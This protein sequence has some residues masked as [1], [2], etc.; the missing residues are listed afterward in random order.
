MKRHAC[1]LLVACA[2][3]C[4]RGPPE[5]AK[6]TTIASCRYDVRLASSG[7]AV[8]DA[9]CQSDGSMSF[10]PAQ[11]YLL[12]YLSANTTNRSGHLR[13]PQAKLRYEV[14]L[15]RLA[16]RGH[17]ADRAARV[18]ESFIAAMSSI[19]LVP[20]PL[21]T[22]IPVTVQLSAEPGVALATGLKRGDA[23][24]AYQ[25]MAH[26]IPVATYLAFGKLEQLEL[27]V[28]GSTLELVR[29][30]GSLDQPSEQLS[31]WIA[32]SAVAVSDFYGAFPMPR[33]SVMVIP[34]PGRES[35]VFGK[36]LPESEPA[37]ALVVGQRATKQKLYQDWILVHE[38]FHLGFPSF[39][40]EG[41]WLDEGLATYYEP[42]IR[43]R[44]GL[45]SER[46]LWRELAQSLP[47]GLEAYTELGLEMASDFRGI[48]W[49]GALACLEADV[50]A[51]RRKLDRGLE[52]GLRALREAGG[53]ANEVWDLADA[54][55]TVDRAL[56]QPTLAPIAERHAT[57]GSAFDLKALLRDLGVHLRSDDTVE[58]R[59][60]A[61][62]AAVRRAITAKP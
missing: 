57:R 20:E 50:S 53:V 42:I 21:T 32:D 27:T 38:L 25:L 46:E 29:L 36:V 7:L 1:A 10:R 48:Y 31:G 9:S 11:H 5:P 28:T 15:A 59:D 56:G 3:A 62:L 6:P 2:S 19:L 35:V 60:D 26:E 34:A 13:A 16:G 39:Y 23:A 43:V 58:L 24:G 47:Q 45:Y 52:V 54:I 18:G 37:I 12:D 14:D 41:K 30:D 51:R 33:A 17:N 61:P 49:G 44:A 8:V 4:F 22:E 40:A 55:A